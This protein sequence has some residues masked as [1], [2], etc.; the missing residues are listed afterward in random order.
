MVAH[1]PD[2]RRF[3]LDGV[4][5]I[6]IGQ[7]ELNYTRYTQCLR[8]LLAQLYLEDDEQVPMFPDLIHTPGESKAKRRRRE[9]GFMLHVRETIADFLQYRD[10][11]IIL[12]DICYEADLDW[13]DFAPIQSENPGEEFTFALLVTTRCRYLLPAAD[14]V[15]I[16]MLDGACAVG[17]KKYIALAILIF[18]FVLFGYRGGCNQLV[19]PRIGREF[20]ANSDGRVTRGP[21]SCS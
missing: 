16:D 13:F 18:V 2:V 7:M 14:T 10:V 21:I 17:Q 1:H 3:F 12:D 20:V 9:E 11:L 8:E 6:Y 15:E 19:N 5:W 4:I